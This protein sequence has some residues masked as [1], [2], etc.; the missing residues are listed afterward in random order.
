[1]EMSYISN[2]ADLLDKPLNLDK[3]AGTSLASTQGFSLITDF[4]R[5]LMVNLRPFNH[6]MNNFKVFS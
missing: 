5:L 4:I 1:M 2:S 6:G 3:T